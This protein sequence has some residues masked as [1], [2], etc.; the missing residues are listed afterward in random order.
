MSGTETDYDMPGTDGVSLAEQIRERWPHTL[1]I[2]ITAHDNAEVRLLAT[3]IA[4]D[5]LLNKQTKLS[6]MKQIVQ[7]MLQNKERH[8]HDRNA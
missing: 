2:L 6:E 5:H 1:T 4:I 7:Q 3:S 8:R